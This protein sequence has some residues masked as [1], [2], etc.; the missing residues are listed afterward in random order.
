MSIPHNH[1]HLSSSS[2]PVHWN[3][4]IGGGGGWINKA[5]SLC[6]PR[7]ND[8]DLQ[9]LF[10]YSIC[11]NFWFLRWSSSSSLVVEVGIFIHCWSC[12]S[13]I[14]FD[15]STSHCIVVGL[16]DSAKGIGNCPT[17]DHT[18]LNQN[19]HPHRLMTDM[20]TSDA[21]P[22]QQQK[23]SQSGCLSF[24]V[25]SLSFIQLSILHKLQS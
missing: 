22:T 9:K 3:R 12:V 13:I 7:M 8:L 17:T 16:G 24:L 6:T 4:V 14:A 5:A 21:M 2:P 10:N 19:L 15:Q 18:W 20:K 25:H 1:P 23:K 11:L